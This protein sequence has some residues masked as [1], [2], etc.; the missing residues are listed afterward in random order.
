M[1]T[2][3]SI[4][5]YHTDK[6]LEN[7]NIIENIDDSYQKIT[8][9]KNNIIQNDKNLVILLIQIMIGDMMQT[10]IPIKNKKNNIIDSI[11]Q[12]SYTAVLQ[13]R[14]ITKKFQN[15]NKYT[16]QNN[17]FIPNIVMEL[18][19]EIFQKTQKAYY[20]LL[21]FLQ[22]INIKKSKTVIT[23]DLSLFPINLKSKYTILIHEKNINYLFTLFDLIHIIKTAITNSPY[24]FP[25]PLEPKNP[26]NN[27]PFTKNQLYYIYLKIRETNITIHPL[28][29]NYYLCDF[30]LEKFILDNEQLIREYSIK[31]YVTDSPITTI[32]DEIIDM[33]NNSR[34]LLKRKLK[35]HK[36]F[37]KKELVEIMKPYLYCYLMHND[38]VDGTNKTRL[39]KRAYQRELNKLIAYNP[40]FGK[41]MIKYE[42]IQTVKTKIFNFDVEKELITKNNNKTDLKKDEDIRNNVKYRRTFCFNTKNPGLTIQKIDKKINN[43][44]S[45]EDDDYYD[46]DNDDDDDSFDQESKVSYEGDTEDEENNADN[47]YDGDTEDEKHEEI[48]ESLQQLF[49]D[50]STDNNEEYHADDEYIDSI[51]YGCDN[52][53][54]TFIK[55]QTNIYVNYQNQGMLWMEYEEYEENEEEQKET[56]SIS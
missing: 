16:K 10:T 56:E 14:Q 9:N 1:K 13:K 35:I 21:K 38:G 47:N 5:Q 33:C 20:A 27:V 2:F 55:T 6:I 46:D 41:R 28:I 54:N 34:N 17:M 45:D 12:D 25:E 37:P 18:I 49:V 50:S 36:D 19:R 42:S 52:N 44:S 23:T 8:T 24:V 11:C 51:E 30:D 4:L 15:Y 31:K 32:H 53:E 7:V 3:T 22:I 29:N 39:F 40:K 26:Y 43:Y 48:L